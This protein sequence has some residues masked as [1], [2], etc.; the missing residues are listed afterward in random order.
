MRRALSV[1]AWIVGKVIYGG[2]VAL[3][4]AV[5]LFGFWVA[6]SLAAFQNVSGWLALLF[7]L[8]CFPM[9]PGGWE[10]VYV[11]R[12]RRRGDERKPILT[13]LDR[14]VLRT[15]IING[16][17]LGLLFWRMPHTAARALVTRGDW[18]FDGYEGG[19]VDHARGAVLRVADLFGKRQPKDTSNGSSDRP[20]PPDIHDDARDDGPVQVKDPNG[21]PYPEQEDELVAQLT[22][23]DE[24]SI[25]TVAHYFASRITDKRRLAKALHDY[26]VERLHYD[27]D[28]YN[29]IMA[30]GDGI[31]SE[32]AADVFAAKTGVCAGYAHLYAAL[33]KAAGL[34]VAYITGWVRNDGRLPNTTVDTDEAIQ[35]AYLEGVGH[36]WNAVKLDGA[37]VPVDTT[38][39]D[40]LS[41][42]GEQKYVTTYLFTP[43]R[44]FIYDHY[45]ED[46]GWQMLAKPIGIGEFS[47]QPGANPYIGVLGASLVEPKRSQITATNGVVDVRV[48][49][50]FHATLAAAVENDECTLVSTETDL[51]TKWTCRVPSGEHQI[52]LFGIPGKPT[53]SV[54]LRAFGTILVNSR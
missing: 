24:Q 38:W 36:A 10:L 25:D 47:R 2:W 45:P 40:P 33:G 31:P 39:D 46:Q 29:K 54:S 9:L 17:F 30:H 37:W 28:T 26:V 42:D 27:V 20:P 5:P 14:L 15:L 43:P 52:H 51:E 21:W 22:P 34:E 11:W 16:L 18:M 4:I 8:A 6:S 3:M 32:E 12:T 23:A 7:G 41:K 48:A 35:K 50:P 19:F 49:N 1:F 13:R 53:S 44:Y